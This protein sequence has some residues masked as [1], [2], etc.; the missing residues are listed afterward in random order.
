[1]TRV[2]RA[3]KKARMWTYYPDLLAR[4]VPRYTS[5][6]TAP[7]FHDGVDSATYGRWLRALKPGQTLSSVGQDYLCGGRF[8]KQGLPQ[9]GLGSGHLV[10]K[11]L[12]F[13]DALDALEDCGHVVDRGFLD[14]KLA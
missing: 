3:F 12:V 4:P 5:Y 1:M 6:P 14:P 8:T 7:H 10:A 11:A 9:A 2:V 13:S